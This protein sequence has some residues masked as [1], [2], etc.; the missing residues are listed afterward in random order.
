MDLGNLL[1]LPVGGGLLYVEPV[2]I[3]ASSGQAYPLLRKVLVA[4][5]D[6]I[7]YDST[8]EG[9]LA[10][11]FGDGTGVDPGDPGDPGEEPGT[12]SAAED[13]AKAL[14]DAQDAD[15]GRGPRA[16]GR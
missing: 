2:Y 5:G 14:A 12:G 9:A 6:R 1:T 10:Q 3:Q 11:V 16:E 13:L 4:F 15:H 7:G 8:L